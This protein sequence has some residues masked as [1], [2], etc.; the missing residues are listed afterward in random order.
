MFVEKMEEREVCEGVHV[1][2]MRYAGEEEGEVCGKGR[3]W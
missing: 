3:T 1:W 2:R